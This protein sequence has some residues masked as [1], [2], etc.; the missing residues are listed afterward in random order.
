M[1][2][3]GDSAAPGRGQKADARLR[4]FIPHGYLFASA[5]V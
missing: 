4:Y 3:F 2:A 1:L 5:A